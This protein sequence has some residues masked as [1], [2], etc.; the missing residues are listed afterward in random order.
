MLTGYSLRLSLWVANHVSLWIPRP[1]KFFINLAPLFTVD[2]IA[3]FAKSL[4]KDLIKHIFFPDN[5]RTDV[6]QL[7]I[8]GD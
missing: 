7:W 3:R 2:D 8:D 1:P 4:M 5:L 6:S